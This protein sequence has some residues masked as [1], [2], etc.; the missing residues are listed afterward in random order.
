MDKL[1]S[2][3]TIHSIMVP[4]HNKELVYT[5]KQTIPTQSLVITRIHRDEDNYEFFGDLRYAIYA[6]GP[7][8][9]EFLWRS[10]SE[11]QGPII[12]FDAND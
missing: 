11:R 6:A 4:L 10:I 9:K 5:V 2:D 8:K 1:Y 3:L 12:T 7:D